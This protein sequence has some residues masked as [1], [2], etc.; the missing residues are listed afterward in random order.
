MASTLLNSGISSGSIVE[1]THVTQIVDAFTATQ[2]YDITLSGSLTV[3]GS[4]VLDT[5][6]DQ[7]FFGTASYVV[8]SSHAYSASNVLYALTTSFADNDTTFVEFYHAPTTIGSNTTVYFS[9]GEFPTSQDERIGWVPPFN[10]RIISASATSIVLGSTGTYQSSIYI[11]S[12]STQVKFTDLTYTNKN[13]F[14]TG[15]VGINFT[16]G[17]RIYCR[18]TTDNNTVP[19]DVSH[20]IILYIKY[21]G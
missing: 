19:T 6:I 10:G 16:S 15:S 2:A 14:G 11:V 1:T 5:I 18:I 12:G 13:Q 8:T 17:S 7:D 4:V 3:T 9:D 20:N 21:N